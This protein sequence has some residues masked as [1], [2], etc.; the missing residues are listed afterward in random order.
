MVLLCYCTIS[1][2]LDGRKLEEKIKNAISEVI[3]LKLGELREA[4]KQANVNT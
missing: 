3:V 1:P 4:A 2:E